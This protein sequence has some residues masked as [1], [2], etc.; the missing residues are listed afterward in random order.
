MLVAMKKPATR[1]PAE[2]ILD[3]AIELTFPASDPISVEHAFRSARKREQA[4]PPEKP[5]GQQARRAQPARRK[6]RAG[7]G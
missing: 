6:A 1:S 4:A 3:R 7:K 2:R 5:P